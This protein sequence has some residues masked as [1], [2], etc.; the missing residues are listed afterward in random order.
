MILFPVFLQLQNCLIYKMIAILKQI[1]K[2]RFKSSLE[3]KVLFF[4]VFGLCIFFCIYVYAL[5]RWVTS[6]LARRVFE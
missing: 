6:V 5:F 3:K 4:H 2:Q 1:N